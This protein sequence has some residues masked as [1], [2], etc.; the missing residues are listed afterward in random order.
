MKYKILILICVYLS[1]VSCKGNKNEMEFINRNKT[2]NFDS[3]YKSSITL[4]G[5]D[6][7]QNVV[8]YIGL[9]NNCKS[10]YKVIFNDKTNKIKGIEKN[11]QIDVCP[12]DSEKIEGMV[13]E[14]LLLGIYVIGMDSNK[15]VSV[16][17]DELDEPVNLFYFPDSTLLE[18][19]N[20]SNLKKLQ[21]NW[22]LK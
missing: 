1:I 22:Y 15:V 18:K 3:F 20:M 13:K 8:C 2:R 9:D 10:S 4:R 17:V 11:N 14:F 16:Q 6:A 5:E 7:N 12:V 19:Y 21:N